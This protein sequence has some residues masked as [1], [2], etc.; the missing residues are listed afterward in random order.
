MMS[1]ELGRREKGLNLSCIICDFDTYAKSVPEAL[2]ESG[3]PDLLQGVEKVLVKPNLVNASPFPVTTRPEC[4]AAVVDFVRSCS[5]A[6][7]VIAEGCG[8]PS[9]ETTDIFRSLGYEEIALQLDVELVDL[10]Y[11]PLRRLADPECAVFPDIFLPEMAFTHFII[12]VPV[13]KAH[14]L[15]G[16]TCSLKSMMGFAP[17][18]YYSG[19]HGIWRKAV[20]HENMHQ[21][22]KDLNKYRTPDFT[23]VDASVGLADY[24]LGGAA[25]NPPVC[26]LVAGADALAVDRECAALLGLDWKTIDHLA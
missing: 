11:A 20:F 5:N 18:Q 25:C 6:S 21:S 22:I 1:P 26:R 10:N 3:L 15:A 12:S 7:I 9:M 19:S 23:L 24:H 14:S 16:I 13:L 8:E 2:D 17:P 4:C